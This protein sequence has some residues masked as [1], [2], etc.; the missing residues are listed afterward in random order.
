M[1]RRDF[2]AL[3]AGLLPVMPLMARSN[4]CLAGQCFVFADA[5]AIQPENVVSFHQAIGGGKRDAG[6][7]DSQRSPKRLAIVP[8]A[9]RYNILSDP[10]V[11]G[12]IIWFFAAS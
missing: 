8:D 4:A 12:L 9:T 11:A 6:Q 2:C 7:D 1:M 10:A 5:D 3:A